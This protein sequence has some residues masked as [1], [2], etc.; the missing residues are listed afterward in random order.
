MQLSYTPVI[1][2]IIRAC[3][4]KVGKN[5]QISW[6]SLYIGA[7]MDLYTFDDDCF[8]GG[9]CYGHNFGGGLFEYKACKIERHAQQRDG[10]QLLPGATIPSKVVTHGSPVV[11]ENCLSAE[12]GLY[13]V[14]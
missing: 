3:G 14:G 12:G 11:I 7:E 8:A 10:C 1:N 9:Q 5:V 13:A 2:F 6:K 4:A